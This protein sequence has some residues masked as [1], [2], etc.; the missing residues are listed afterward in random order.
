MAAWALSSKRPTR[1]CVDHPR[2]ADPYL[3]IYLVIFARLKS[4]SGSQV[5]QG[6]YG[7]GSSTVTLGV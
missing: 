1:R 5:C 6:E 4:W 2:C 3:I 7:P